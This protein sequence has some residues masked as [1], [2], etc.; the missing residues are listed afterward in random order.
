MRAEGNAYEQGDAY[1][2]E[3]MASV[4]TANLAME[5]LQPHI[6]IEDEKPVAGTAVIGTA[7]GDIHDIGKNLVRIM[8][9]SSDIKVTDLGTEVP[10]ASFVEHVRN[11]PDCNLVLIS[12]NRSEST[13]EV[14]AVVDAFKDAKLRDQLFIM[15]GGA[16]AD[17]AL[18]ASVGA[19]AYTVNA[20]DAA[21]TAREFLSL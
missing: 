4:S 1:M 6:A 2:T 7:V 20:E 9:E 12:V 11:N 21:T 10:A 14:R 8:L 5:V 19:D 13:E 3:M 18:A 15:V 16:A 17:E